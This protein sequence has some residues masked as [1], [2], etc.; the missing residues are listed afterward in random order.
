MEKKLKIGDISGCLEVV[1]TCTD[2]EKDLINIEYQWAL[3]EWN[4]YVAR[5]FKKG[6]MPDSFVEE[7][8]NGPYWKTDVL[9][10]KLE[11]DEE[12]FLYKSQ[13]PNTFYSLRN[14]FCLKKLYKVKCNHCGRLLYTDSESF[15]CS[16]WRRCVKKCSENSS[17]YEADY[18]NNLYEWNSSENELQLVDTQ[19]ALVEELSYPLTYYSEGG[20]FDSLKIA[21]ISDIHLLH[22]LEY[23]ENNVNK[24]IKDI[25]ENL[26]LSQ[27]SKITI[28]CGDISS[29]TPMVI[30]F[31]NQYRYRHNYPLFKQFKDKLN[32]LK[33]DNLK[34]STIP[35]S[36]YIKRLDNISRYIE[37][38]K[39]AIKKVF[40]FSVFEK[41]KKTYHPNI[42]YEEA[43][44]HFKKTN[45]FRKFKVTKRVESQIIEILKLLT[46]KA[47]YIF[48]IECEKN[49]WEQ[50]RL[51][52]EQWE[53]KYSKSIEEAF[54]ND[55][56]LEKLKDV[57]YVLGNHEYIDFPDIQS[58]VNFYKE[59]LSKLGV[60]VL[61]NE[62]V[63]KDKY[64]L[65]GG[66]GFAKYDK[67]YNANTIK[68]SPGLTREEEITE[69]AEFEKGYKQAL[70]YAKEKKLCFICA[71][72]YPV[73][74]CLNDVY[75]KE[76]IYFTGHNHHNE[77]VKNEDKVL[78]ADNQI[79]YDKRSYDNKNMT[80]KI[81]STGFE[82][83]PYCEL[84]DGLY[85]TT[86]EDYLQFYRYLGEDVGKGRL[87]YQRCQNGTFYIVKRRGYYGFF[88]V[89]TKKD[90]KGISIVN[91]GMT[92]KLTTSTD[93]SWICENFDAV[94][95][96][97]LQML[98]PLRKAQE[99]LS[100]ELKELDLNGTIH[101]L[102]VDIDR[103]NPS[104]Y[105]IALNPVEGNLQFYYSSKWGLVM[106]LNSFDEV[107][108]SLEI[109]KSEWDNTDYKL[110]QSKYKEKSKNNGY[111]LSM[112]ANNY[113]LEAESYELDDISQ[114]TEQIV[115]RTEGMYAV[116]RKISPLQRLFTGRV[117]RDFDLRLTETE[118]QSSHRKKL[119]NGR[120]FK[121][122]GIR[123]QIVEDNGGDII[124]AEKLQK[125]SRS[126][127][128]GIKLS[129]EK[130]RFAIEELK[131]K[132]K[133]RDEWDTYWM[134]E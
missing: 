111:L 58:G 4:H 37:K 126:K 10:R 95:S 12:R 48:N 56:E 127:G 77:Y 63:E 42:G 88:I 55:Y 102:I 116:S 89:S 33:K 134:D 79:G 90:S 44:D 69:T 85:Q 99:E 5:G 53:E 113:L 84:C 15:C 128:S 107:I 100:K 2:A 71:T 93:I 87:L 105:H 70:A 101:G 36:R 61:Q 30:Y 64:L 46:I 131:A 65:Y 17:V 51:R 83:N 8:K 133:K 11:N 98:L 124:T 19:L 114:R 81:A 92:K 35:Q 75:D 38:K 97:Y 28:F 39:N 45:S 119:Y 76:T 50:R 26:Y 31:F 68:C 108:K 67:K 104:L 3:E 91:G 40:D 41:Y 117:L 110:I 27:K 60:T 106:E 16:K 109:H 73:S 34:L 49:D 20:Y 129:G 66:T 78:Y 24:M 22:H 14:N 72:H 118:Q 6:H 82:I 94:V 57:Y 115:S 120:V 47:E 54:I 86:V 130:K 80:F 1:G 32:Q 23:Y 52:I 13:K 96:K 125:G 7:W 123:Y 43:Y 132:I 121:Y 112:T 21:Y 29:S 74:A 59:N 122:E 25:V 62:F 103:G 9:R 18:T